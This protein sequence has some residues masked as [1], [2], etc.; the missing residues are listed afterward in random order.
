MNETMTS[1]FFIAGYVQPSTKKRRQFA[2]FSEIAIKP[3][4]NV[5]IWR[6]Y[7]RARPNKTIWAQIRANL[8]ASMDENDKQ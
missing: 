8:P 7:W 3:W 4:V 2:S 6:L 1:I 5:N